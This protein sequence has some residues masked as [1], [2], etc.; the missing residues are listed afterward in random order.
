MQ[1]VKYAAK[2]GKK[3]MEQVLPLTPALAG[4]RM[5]N[6]K[7]FSDLKWDREFASLFL[8]LLLSELLLIC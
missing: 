1:V 2:N 6:S 7:D 5:K 4:L 8:M 3:K